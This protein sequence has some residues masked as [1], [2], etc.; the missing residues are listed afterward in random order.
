MQV[1]VLFN[2]L[3]NATA[4]HARPQSIIITLSAPLSPSE[5]KE[6]TVSPALPVTSTPDAHNTSSLPSS[7]TESHFISLT[8][9]FALRR[10]NTGAPAQRPTQSELTSARSSSHPTSHNP[11]HPPPFS[12]VNLPT[13]DR[14]SVTFQLTAQL[15][16]ASTND[17]TYSPFNHT[18]NTKSS[19][20]LHELP[21]PDVRST[22]NSNKREISLSRNT[23]S[24]RTDHTSTSV[25]NQN[26]I[27]TTY[28]PS[29]HF[30]ALILP[31]SSHTST[32]TEINQR[33]DYIRKPVKTKEYQAQP[34]NILET[35]PLTHHEDSSENIDSIDS[36][37]ES[38]VAKNRRIISRIHFGSSQE[39]ER[40]IPLN[41]LSPLREVTLSLNKATSEITSLKPDSRPY[42]QKTDKEPIIPE[43]PIPERNQHFIRY[44]LTRTTT[45]EQPT[46]HASTTRSYQRQDTVNQERTT[47]R[48]TIPQPTSSINSEYFRSSDEIKRP[49]E[50]N[51]YFKNVD[52]HHE[53]SRIDERISSTTAKNRFNFNGSPYDFSQND[54]KDGQTKESDKYII[55]RRHYDQKSENQTETNTYAFPRRNPIGFSHRLEES[56]DS[57]IRRTTEVNRFKNEFSQQNENEETSTR[58]I[59]PKRNFAFSTTSEQYKVESTTK[60][61]LPNRNYDILEGVKHN[62]DKYISANRNHD[63]PRRN[64]DSTTV[65]NK[66]AENTGQPTTYRNHD[67]LQKTT[68]EH[69]RYVVPNKI[70]D[71]PSSTEENR[72]SGSNIRHL[73][74][75]KNDDAQWTSTTEYSRFVPPNRNF[76]I[77]NAAEDKKPTES[78]RYFASNKNHDF[79]QYSTT[80]HNRIAAPNRHPGFSNTEQDNKQTESNVRYQEP[81]RNYDFSQKSTTESLKYTTEN[82]FIANSAVT[83]PQ[84]TEGYKQTETSRFIKPVRNP[85][86]FS[87]KFEPSSTEEIKQV[88]ETSRFIKSNRNYDFS[89]R[90]SQTEENL[91]KTT[92]SNKYTTPSKNNLSHKIEYS[93]TENTIKQTTSRFTSKSAYDFSKKLT[94]TNYRDNEPKKI[95]EPSRY[96]RPY[97]PTPE[98]NVE[99]NSG[100]Y[101]PTVEQERQKTFRGNFGHNRFSPINETRNERYPNRKDNT[102]NNRFVVERNTTEYNKET[103]TERFLPTPSNSF[104]NNMK[105]YLKYNSEGKQIRGFKFT[106]ETTPASTEED[107]SQSYE[108]VEN[109]YEPIKSTEKPILPTVIS[110]IDCH[111]RV[112]CELIKNKRVKPFHATVEIPTVPEIIA[113]IEEQSKPETD[114]S[115]TYKLKPV[116]KLDLTNNT[117]TYNNDITQTQ[118]RNVSLPARISR[119]N[120]AIKSL[121]AF[122]G[123]GTG[124]GSRRTS[125]KCN[126]NQTAPNVKCNEIQKERY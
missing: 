95:N 101:E 21:S 4:N 39:L 69:S 87:Q 82:R 71:F 116:E 79:S 74:S 9:G 6:T 43:H 56:T 40:I 49:S 37:S 110:Q 98:E 17:T 60:Q 113:S 102:S 20:A 1:S 61:A 99:D 105:W 3:P 91:R 30:L 35:S 52:Q 115:P 34:E 83:Q 126:E 38:D 41:K 59:A 8:A 104:K 7:Q 88:T 84:T 23:N 65:R 24:L 106:M 12:P 81:N 33:N 100:S 50:N 85:Y 86:D 16:T 89:Q 96:I 108:N 36:S 77:S 124:T 67:I 92:E 111:D 2:R 73:I 123:R 70:V 97:K 64:E 46:T 112:Q 32:T 122:G 107:I 118:S 72:P 19:V 11:Q 18:S 63:F 51:R 68:T 90:F 80:E 14:K 54:D 13:P 66:P 120:T 114:N 117:L 94:Q 47:Q 26:I 125:T 22:D 103:T 29:K 62:E 119:V 76:D 58:F 44:P 42:L 78:S 5:H 27:P 93:T 10:N 45:E 75:N 28:A 55:P 57:N 121:I 53:D 109:K 48:I 31:K 25:S 15:A